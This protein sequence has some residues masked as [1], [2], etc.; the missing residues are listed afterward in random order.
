MRINKNQIAQRFIKYARIETTSN[1]ASGNCP[2]TPGQIELAKILM[3]DLLEA[4]C[5]DVH[6]NEFGYL[7][8]TLPANTT[9]KLPVIGL[10]AHLDTSPD[11]QGRDV[12]PR[13]VEKYPGGDIPL[14]PG[15]KIMLRPTDFPELNQYIGQDLI[16]TDGNTLLGADDKAGIAVIIEAITHLNQHPEIRHGQV[17]IC[18]TPD[19]EIG[20]GADRFDV[21]RF[22][23]D[24]AYTIDGGAIGDLEYE[25]FNA[26]AASIRIHGRN[27]HPGTAKDK[28]INAIQ[29]AVDFHNQLPKGD[30]PEHTEGYEGFFH[31]I[32]LN[33]GVE[34]A[35]LEYI[36]RDHDS[37]NF[38]ERKEMLRN[39][40][41]RFN[42]TYPPKTVE[43][44]IKDQYFNMKEKIE[45]VIYIVELAAE[46]MRMVGIEP[47]IAPIR[48]GTDGARLSFM[49]LPTPNLFTGGHNF[50]GRYEFIPIQSMVASAEVI[51]NLLMIAAKSRNK[52]S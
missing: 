16:V 13:I 35:R 48:G 17:K 14:D 8:A 21:Q 51:I 43:L 41:S 46:A 11:L 38:A 27:V 40:T 5:I 44:V 22:G 25:N 33:G 3:I 49:G 28:M 18:F 1:P 26:A 36:I 42:T 31:L 24:F 34:K 45:P 15:E 29:L 6:L 19:E 12:N 7:T 32:R 2:S 50:H 30:R 10:I 23:A 39:I 47:R 37:K 9:D 4:G 20:R 52:Q